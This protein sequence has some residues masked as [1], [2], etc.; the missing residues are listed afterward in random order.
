MEELQTYK[1]TS[2]KLRKDPKF[3]EL[4]EEQDAKNAAMRQQY[5]VWRNAVAEK[6]SDVK[7]AMRLEK[8]VAEL[9][10][11]SQTLN[12]DLSSLKKS[13]S[14]LEEEAASC[15]SEVDELRGLVEVASRWENDARRIATKRME[16]QQKTLD[17]NASTASN[18]GRDLH[19]MEAERKRKVEEREAAM[20]KAA[21]IT[22]E[23]MKL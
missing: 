6:L 12:E 17:I 14:Q 18:E 20:N 10:Q 3:I 23:S 7:D 15:E 21:A 8:E 22:K 9:E 16:I 19:E 11:D 5:Q 2:E 4:D 1:E 13:I